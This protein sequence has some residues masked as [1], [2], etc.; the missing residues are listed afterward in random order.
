MVLIA[1]F[2]LIQSQQYY[3]IEEE[4]ADERIVSVCAMGCDY[5]VK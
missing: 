4:V 5:I 1:L 3:I 2:L